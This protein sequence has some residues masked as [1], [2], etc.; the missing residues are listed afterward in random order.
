MDDSYK[1]A[2]FLSWL[3][4]HY[5]LLPITFHKSGIKPRVGVKAMLRAK[6]DG[7]SGNGIN[8]KQN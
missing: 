3:S 5:L 2:F 6:Q 4:S 1:P 8:V 7:V